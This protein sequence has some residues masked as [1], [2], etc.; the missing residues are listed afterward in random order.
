ML[1]RTASAAPLWAPL[2]LSAM[3][4]G[5]GWGIRGQYGHE[6]GAM[7]AGL[8]VG[9]VL[10]LFFCPRATSLR[11]ARAVALTAIAFS[12]GGSMTYGQT[13]GLTHDAPL[14]G[15]WGAL[16][17]GLLGLFIKG[18]VWIGF[19]GAFL[20]M[21]LGG[22]R[23]RPLECAI[24]L[25]SLVALLFVGLA[26]VN[27]PFNPDARE[28]PAVYFSDDWQWEPDNP[29]VSPRRECWG[30][31]WAALIGLVVYLAWIKKDRLG[32]NMA[33]VGMLAGGF[34]FVTGQSVQA[35]R[36]WSPELF[37]SGGFASVDRY[38][39]WW[40]MMEITFGTVLGAGL[41][42]GLWLNRRLVA[43]NDAD[44][45]PE[46]SP[47][48]EWWLVLLHAVAL[49]AEGFLSFQSFD[50]VADHGLPMGLLPIIGIVGGRRW[51]YLLS[52]PLLALPIAGKTL[53]QMSY[54]TDQVDV[55]TGWI[56]FVILPLA[57]MVVAA[58]FFASP[59]RSDRGGRFF[60]RW[61]LVLT[62]W[63][64][65][66]LNFAFFE[67]P[68]PWVEPTGRTPS[69]WIFVV[70]A[71]GLTIGAWRGGQRKLKEGVAVTERE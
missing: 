25:L 62:S 52:L 38:M 21:G 7:L 55:T 16:S 36:Q 41:A 11:A 6:T 61:A 63:F 23:Y 30:G 28:L 50:V 12:F 45:E 10:V 20:G 26:F 35:F 1:S 39:N 37:T 18:A 67:F 24:L 29:G 54:R 51:P 9:L 8:L 59:A 47:A 43:A 49:V 58:L 22:A 44:D 2:C 56:V 19:G 65:F 17:W 34:G 57:L 71:V 14:I 46:L 15:N 53:R 48:V 13:V 31:L 64:Y 4:G 27:E 66:S 3:A 32:R 70:C 42:L 68:W 40:N 5:M 33:L 60:T 69:A